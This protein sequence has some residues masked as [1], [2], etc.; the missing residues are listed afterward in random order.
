MCKTTDRTGGV[1]FA[2]FRQLLTVTLV[3]A[4]ARRAYQASAP[5]RGNIFGVSG[6][7]P[8]LSW[9]CVFAS[10]TNWKQETVLLYFSD[11]VTLAATRL[12]AAA[13]APIRVGHPEEGP[14]VP[15][16][17]L[18]AETARPQRAAGCM[19]LPCIGCW[20][21]FGRRRHGCRNWRIRRRDRIRVRAG[22]GEIQSL[23]AAGPDLAEALP[24]CTGLQA[25]GVIVGHFWKSR[26]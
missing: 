18:P 23:H 14:H 6:A 10:H 20:A 24:S 4:Y 3:S 26:G 22:R 17:A 1:C 12:Q 19:P 2:R 16:G 9:R 13:A 25:R 21:S 15:E 11:S 8:C 7:G 5:E